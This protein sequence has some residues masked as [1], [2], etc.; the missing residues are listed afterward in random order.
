MRYLTEHWSFD[1]LLAVAL[2]AVVA[3]EVG[4]WRLARR[5]LP[6]HTR[7]RRLRSLFFYAAV[8]VLVVAVDSPI[9]HWSYRYFF[10]HMFG[11][12]LVSIVVPVLVVAGVPWIPWLH[13][14]PVGLRRS[15]GRVVLLGR[16]RRV[17]WACARFVRAPWTA[18]VAFNASMVL[19]HLPGALDLAER[20]AFVHTWIMYGSLFL[21]GVLF[22][23]QILPSHPFAPRATAVWQI[24]AI[25]STN[26]VMFVLAM[27]MSIL[28]QHSWYPSYAHVP[29]VSLSPFADQQIGAAVLWVC[30]DFWAIPALVVVVKRAVEE[31]GSLSQLIDAVVRRAAGD[32]GD[33]WAAGPRSGQSP[34]ADHMVVDSVDPPS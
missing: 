9:E 12:I 7:R 24:G 18:L 22:W 33:P 10:V 20:N 23:L 3:L 2:V 34:A 32:G 1:P 26:V 27:S 21:T 8:I 5:S 13:A 30:G 16:G 17:L 25:I 6:A 31:Q 28:T 4:L 29:G 19:W 14:V 15:L 11:H